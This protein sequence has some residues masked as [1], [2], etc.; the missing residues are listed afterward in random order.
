LDL[1]VRFR[2]VCPEMRHTGAP[3]VHCSPKGLSSENSSE[4]SILLN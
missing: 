4:S 3:A 2:R 1:N